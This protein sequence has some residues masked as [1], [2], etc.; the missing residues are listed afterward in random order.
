MI[1][2][3]PSSG[4]NSK[5]NLFECYFLI[6][7]VIRI[8]FSMSLC[9]PNFRCHSTNSQNFHVEFYWG[10]CVL[11]Q[12]CAICM[13]AVYACRGLNF[14]SF[15]AWQLLPRW[16]ALGSVNKWWSDAGMARV[17]RIQASFWWSTVCRYSMLCGP[18]GVLISCS[19]TKSRVISSAVC[20][21]LSSLDASLHELTGY[22]AV[23]KKKEQRV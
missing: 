15:V 6:C 17:C 11:S 20:E 18:C 4:P 3:N 2:S 23:Q 13:Q 9:V 10:V 5:M 14:G 12:S 16:S 1:D 7:Q 22:Q 21:R 8:S 19:A